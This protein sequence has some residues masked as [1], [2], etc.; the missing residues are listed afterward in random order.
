MTA[1]AQT[2]FY[3]D[4]CTGEDNVSS[5]N[6]PTAQRVSGPAGWLTLWLRD[7]TGPATHL[8]PVCAPAYEAFMKGDK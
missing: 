6:L 4:R 2:R 1:Q 7:P 8:C 5:Q 3:C